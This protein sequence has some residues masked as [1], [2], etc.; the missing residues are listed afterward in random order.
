VATLNFAILF[1]KASALPGRSNNQNLLDLKIRAGVFRGKI[2]SRFPLSTG[3]LRRHFRIPNAPRR[4][5]P[6]HFILT[7]VFLTVNNDLPGERRKLPRSF[8][9]LLKLWYLP[10]IAGAAMHLHIVCPGVSIDA[11]MKFP[12]A[13]IER[14]SPSPTPP[15]RPLPQRHHPP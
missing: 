12:P 11:D 8:F 7:T 6:L 9:W 2:K 5:C 14:T 10:I 3:T 4:A 13:E 1:S 15:R